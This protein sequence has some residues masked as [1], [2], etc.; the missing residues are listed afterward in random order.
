MTDSI[1]KILTV[2][3]DSES[4]AEISKCAALPQSVTPA[5]IQ[6]DAN[7]IDF[8]RFWTEESWKDAV[9]M[10]MTA[11]VIIVSLSGRS[12]LPVP[13]KRWME[14]WPRHQRAKHDALVVVVGRG[15][16][17]CPRQKALVSYFRQIAA[18]HGLDFFCNRDLEQASAL[19]FAGFEP[20]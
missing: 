19:S 5:A 7:S 3:E 13:V 20:N 17:D 6:A 1:S 10:A 8:L 15:E 4:F 11:D 18:A 12:D 9:A 14:C 16:R 2:Y